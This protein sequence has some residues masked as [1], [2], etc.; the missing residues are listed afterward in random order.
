MNKPALSPLLSK[1]YEHLGHWISYFQQV[2]VLPSKPAY[3]NKVYVLLDSENLVV[4]LPEIVHHHLNQ[5]H[6]TFPFQNSPLPEN[7]MVVEYE[8]DYLN[9]QV[10]LPGDLV[11][12]EVQTNRHQHQHPPQVVYEV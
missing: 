5:I 2:L 4:E 3:E 11:Q 12:R 1:M 7:L 10:K 6:Y 8:P 9:F